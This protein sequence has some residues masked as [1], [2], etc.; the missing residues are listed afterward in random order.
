MRCWVVIVAD[1][2]GKPAAG[3]VTAATLQAV[4]IAPLN[5]HQGGFKDTTLW[6]PIKLPLRCNLWAQQYCKHVT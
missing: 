6:A 4:H 1:R 2:V 3:R 5:H